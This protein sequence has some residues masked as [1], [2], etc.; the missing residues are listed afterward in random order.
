MTAKTE[1]TTL[2]QA[3]ERATGALRYFDG[4]ILNG[5][6]ELSDPSY[7]R[8]QLRDA[9]RAIL[10]ALSAMD[11]AEKAGWTPHTE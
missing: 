2:L 1:T 9:S 6:G 11:R 3:T 7:A 10:E 5:F 8:G 4:R